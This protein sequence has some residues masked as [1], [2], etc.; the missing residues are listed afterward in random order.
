MA[1]THP[2][3]G[4]RAVYVYR[5]QVPYKAKDFV[6]G[7]ERWIE[8]QVHGPDGVGVARQWGQVP[9]L[10][11]RRVEDVVAEAVEIGVCSDSQ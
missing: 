11:R 7:G 4:L 9:L 1:C 10:R 8:D 5:L 3:L 6:M 2:S